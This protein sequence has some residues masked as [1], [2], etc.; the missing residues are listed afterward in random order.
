M[1]ICIELIILALTTDYI[2]GVSGFTESWKGWIASSLHKRPADLKEL[3]PFD[4]SACMTWWVCLIWCI[5]TGNFTIPCIGMCALLSLLSFPF[6]S[7]L[8]FIREALHSLID[9]LEGWL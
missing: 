5:V 1:K 4:C 3:K 2:V 9:K 6:C 8:I 7:L